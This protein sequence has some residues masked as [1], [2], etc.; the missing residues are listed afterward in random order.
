MKTFILINSPIFWDSKAEDE[1]YLSPLGQGYIATYLDLSGVH[2]ELL[3]C[4]KAKKSVDEVI[5]YIQIRNPD[6][7]GINIFTQNYEIVRYITEHIRPRCGIFIGGQAVKSIYREIM[8]WTVTTPL[9]LIIGEGEFIIPSIVTETCIQEPEERQGLMSMYRVNRD[10][11][12]FPADI[13][14]IRLNRKFMGNEVI[15][16]HYG[17]KET[18]IITSRG[19]M[20]DCAFC[21]G[22]RSLNRDVTIRIR[23]VESVKREI[24]EIQALHP[25]IE[26]IRVL[27]DLFLRG[28]ASIDA[29]CRIF[30]AFPKLRWRGMAHVISLYPALEEMER[31]NAN[32]C[33]EL[34][35]GI[36]SGSVSM[37]KNIN[38]LGSPEQVFDVISAI[39]KSGIDVKGYFIYGFPK[40]TLKD[41]QATF[42]LASRLKSLS[43]HTPGNFRTSVFQ[44]RPYHGTQLYEEIVQDNGLI[45]EMRFNENLS[46]FRNRSQFNFDSGNYSAETDAVLNDYILKTQALNGDEH[47]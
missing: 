11:P 23:T 25:D 20:F 43:L 16:N 1:Q 4:V 18:G 17:K 10:S 46:R 6:Y 8:K 5:Q 35:I 21:G 24:E 7:A 40:E 15:V 13:S 38:K 34:F 45:H 2:V 44:F 39:L 41:F 9:Y 29:A 31:L 47:D 26:Y 36:E 30:S 37:R 27:D 3:D 14:D 32:G 12:Y 42:D 19:C 33:R 28:K 22:A